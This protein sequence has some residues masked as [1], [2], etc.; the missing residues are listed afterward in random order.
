[1]F[2]IYLQKF[3]LTGN[4]VLVKDKQNIPEEQTRICSLY[5]G[6]NRPNKI[7]NTVGNLKIAASLKHLLIRQAAFFYSFAPL[8]LGP[9]YTR[10]VF[11]F[12]ETY[13]I[14]DNLKSL[15][16]DRPGQNLVH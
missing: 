13:W 4:I 12:R 7:Y 8:P 11:F 16:Y 14:T 2:S 5:R 6:G 10:C 15:T 3:A 9:K 1:L